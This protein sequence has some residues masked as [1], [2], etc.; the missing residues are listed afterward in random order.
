MNPPRNP[1]P[2]GYVPYPKFHAMVNKWKSRALRAEDELRRREAGAAR[3]PRMVV[4]AIAQ[5]VPIS[6]HAETGRQDG[7]T[8]SGESGGIKREQDPI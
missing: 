3:R 6:P 2:P 7:F 1:P 5:P 8:T 4:A